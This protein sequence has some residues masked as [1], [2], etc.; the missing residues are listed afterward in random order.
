M[1]EKRLP[2]YQFDGVF[3][4]AAML[5]LHVSRERM[6][7]YLETQ[8][9][10]SFNQE[11]KAHLEIAREV[12][13]T[14]PGAIA[15]SCGTYEEELE[16]TKRVHGLEDDSQGNSLELEKLKQYIIKKLSGSSPR[17]IYREM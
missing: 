6:L 2:P 8:D 14:K 13:T 10:A 11:A 12:S 7:Y 1:F 9:W 3:N 5:R 4:S 17:Y 15:T 16:R